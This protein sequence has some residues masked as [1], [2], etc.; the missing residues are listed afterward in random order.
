MKI[1]ISDTTNNLLVSCSDVK[2]ITEERDST[3]NSNKYTRY[4]VES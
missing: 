1:H 4:S 3:V 2:Y